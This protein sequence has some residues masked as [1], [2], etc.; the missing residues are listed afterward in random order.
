MVSKYLDVRQVDTL[1][2]QRNIF[3]SAHACKVHMR[4]VP[5]TG[6]I[7]MFVLDQVRKGSLSNKK[8]QQQPQ[9]CFLFQP[10]CSL[11]VCIF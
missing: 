7:G 3:E 1:L 9:T 5:Y 10:L 6:Y 8:L 2:A 11:V 4:S